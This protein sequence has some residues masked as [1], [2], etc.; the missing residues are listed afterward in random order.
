MLEKF[1]IPEQNSLD[2]M[3]GIETSEGFKLQT[4]PD[5]EIRFET[6]I[7]S[8][9]KAKSIEQM[10]RDNINSFDF[11]AEGFFESLV[12]AEES[13][14]NEKEIKSYKH[15]HHLFTLDV[16]NRLVERGILGEGDKDLFCKSLPL[17]FEWTR[18]IESYVAHKGTSQRLMKEKQIVDLKLITDYFL[19]HLNTLMKHSKIY[20]I[21]GVVS[22]RI[23]LFKLMSD[24]RQETRN[25]EPPVSIEKE[26]KEYCLKI[27]IDEGLKGLYPGIVNYADF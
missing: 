26:W 23:Y 22:E 3:E 14:L 20:E 13:I 6:A 18:V 16:F 10:I 4:K 5:E 8:L 2:S 1:N 25:I 21:D 7:L 15:I 9:E 24:F 17:Y 12:K 19:P 27:N 11:F